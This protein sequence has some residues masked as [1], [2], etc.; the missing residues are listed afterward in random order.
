LLEEKE[1]ASVQKNVTNC[2]INNTFKIIGKKFT[3]LI[4]RNM[5][6]LNQTRFNQLLD[7]I[8]EINAK[9]LSVRLKEMQKDGLVER[10]IYPGTPVKVE[11]HITG[12]G[13]A[14]IPILYQMAKFSIQYCPKDVF[15]DKKP[16]TVEELFG[17]EPRQS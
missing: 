12:K 2:P 9:T 7:S 10:K 1:I 4:L 11:Y 17:Y 16:R 8:E 6:Y 15:K 3:I 13:R 5:I 14:L